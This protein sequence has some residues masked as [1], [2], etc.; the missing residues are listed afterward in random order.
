[1]QLPTLDDKRVS[2]VA[3]LDP[4]PAEELVSHSAVFEPMPTEKLV[5]HVAV[6]NPMPIELVSLAAV[7]DPMPA[8]KLVSQVAV[9]DPSLTSCPVEEFY[10]ILTAEA[11]SQ[12]GH[13]GSLLV[14]A[15]ILAIVA[16]KT[17]CIEAMHLCTP[18]RIIR[19]IKRGS[20]IFDVRSCAAFLNFWLFW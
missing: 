2:H 5:S 13:S 14:M 19:S 6:L 15:D 8:D 3:V 12:T 9:L 4:T 16:E 11:S 10:C 17:S 18:P 7:L 1:M 20:G